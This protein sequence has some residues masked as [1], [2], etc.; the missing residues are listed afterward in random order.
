MATA[1][2][3]PSCLG[4]ELG[5][6]E[7]AGAGLGKEQLVSMVRAGEPNV[8]SLWTIVGRVGL[9]GWSGWGQLKCC[10]WALGWEPVV[11]MVT[12]RGGRHYLHGCD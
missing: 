10:C 7:E 2:G 11:S 8:G 12:A 9:H 6:W 5:G 4:V 3:G 1:V